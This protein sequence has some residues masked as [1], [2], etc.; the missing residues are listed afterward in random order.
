MYNFSSKIY[1]YICILVF[2]F[3]ITLLII[4]FSVNWH[5][6][7][8]SDFRKSF[9]L[10]DGVVWLI[11]G[12]IFLFIYLFKYYIYMSI[13]VAIGLLISSLLL[14]KIHSTYFKKGKY[15]GK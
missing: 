7:K 11:F 13:I 14:L 12:F 1:L 15:I 5:N 8:Y 3:A 10:V 9:L 4:R 6:K 2:G